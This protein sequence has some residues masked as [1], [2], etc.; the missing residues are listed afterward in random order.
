LDLVSPILWISLNAIFGEPLVGALGERLTVYHCTDEVSTTPNLSPHLPAIEQAMLA[1]TGLAIASSR[2]LVEAKRLYCANIHFVPNAADVSFFEQ[3]LSPDTLVPDD[4]AALP[5]PRIIFVGALD[6]RFD[7]SLLAAC[8]RS[9]P[10]WSWVLVGPED[11][12]TFD[13]APLAGQPNIYR[14]GLRPR[15]VVPGYLRGSDAAIIPYHLTEHTRNVYP[16][17]LHEYLAAGKPVV[18]TPLP[19]LV[20]FEPVIRLASETDEFIDALDGVLTEDTEA[21]L[22]DRLDVA[23]ANDWSQRVATIEGLIDAALQT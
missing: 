8:A 6:F 20:E 4:L 13:V 21:V 7:T 15:D 5:S 11:R 18:T 9:R 22:Q 16:L 10:G 23:R 2:A 17:K 12:A 3:A 1:R 14:L 19:D